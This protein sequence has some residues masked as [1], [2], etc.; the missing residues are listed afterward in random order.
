MS[1]APVAVRPWKSFS[2]PRW[3]NHSR[4]L[5]RRT[6]SPTTENRKCPGSM[7]PACTGP[8]G[9]SYTPSPS[10]VRNGKRPLAAKSG[11]GPALARIGCQSCGQCAWRTI[12]RGRGCP[13]S[14]IPY[15]SIISRS[16]R[17]AGNDRCARERSAGV[18]RGSVRT[19]SSRRSGIPARNSD[20]IRIA[21][22]SS[23]AATNASRYPAASIS[24]VASGCS[25][26]LMVRLLRCALTAAP[27]VARR[28]CATVP[29][30][31]RRRHRAPGWR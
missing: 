27:R 24:P 22:P 5:S 16:K 3:T 14:S 29:S 8:T 7:S 26:A 30:R 10:T 17:P 2:M 28:R 11:G 4:I 25:S 6:V 12:R 21:S 15:R 31:V 20:T 9:I 23:W 13:I 18:S 1:A 19:S